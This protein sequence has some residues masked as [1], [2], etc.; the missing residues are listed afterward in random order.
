MTH[1]EAVTRLRPKPDL[2]DLAGL[3]GALASVDRLRI[4]R[5]MADG[6]ER[7]PKMLAAFLAPAPLGRVSYH[8][9]IMVGKGLLDLTRVEPARGALQHFYVISDEGRWLKKWVRL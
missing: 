6:K 2:E 1:S 7:S 8:V 9:R 4:L 5:L 3:L